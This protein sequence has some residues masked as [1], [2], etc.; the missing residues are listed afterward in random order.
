M[1]GRAI[2]WLLALGHRPART[3]DPRLVIVRHHRVYAAS[4]RPLYRLGVTEAV[5]ERQ[6]ALLARAGL[7]PVA[8]AEG[9]ARIA[10]GVPGTHVAFTFDDGY[11][12]NATRAVPLLARHGAR[13]T[14]YLAAGLMDERRA[15]WWDELAHALEHARTPR[16]TL[17]LGGSPVAVDAGTPAGRADALRALLPAMRV[18]P[19]EQRVRLD[20]LRAA[21]G[22]TEPAPCELADWAL[23]RT[24]VDTGM[25]VGAHTL[26]H[27]FL[28]LL[29]PAAQRRE[30]EGSMRL[31]AERLGTTPSGL[32]YPNGDHDDVTVEAARAS[33]LAYA[34][35]TRSGDV[36][37]GA[38]PFRLARRG[39]PEG[40]CLGP[41]GRFSDR[42]TLAEIH[43]AFDSLRGRRAEVGT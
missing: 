17:E 29:D 22:V 16:A 37:P 7:A 13:A 27:P 12:D 35:T 28:S 24:F 38:P 19:A 40:A 23:A 33:G 42:M 4:E 32:A 34:V 26:S 43:G 25:E 2:R 14:F 18:P 5:L 30:I 6:L 39:L 11:A 36:A 41:G 8:A 1:S 3:G 15:P 10:A 21:L 9:L 20:R 31:V